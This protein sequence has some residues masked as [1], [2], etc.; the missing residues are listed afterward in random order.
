MCLYSSACKTLQE[1]RDK[2]CSDIGGLHTNKQSNDCTTTHFP[3]FSWVV[4]YQRENLTFPVGAACVCLELSP[5][6]GWTDLQMNSR[7]TAVIS[8]LILTGLHPCS[9]QC[10][11]LA[12]FLQQRLFVAE[13]FVLHC[14]NVILITKAAK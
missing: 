13:S 9:N 1:P 5:Y 11:T 12:F 8:L 2:M 10:C 3:S 14:I 4:R 6:I 7:W